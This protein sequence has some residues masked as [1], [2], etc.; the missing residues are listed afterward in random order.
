MEE[1]DVV[2]RNRVFNSSEKSQKHQHQGACSEEQGQ[3]A[4]KRTCK[5]KSA[6]FIAAKEG[7][8]ESNIRAAAMIGV[9][10]SDYPSNLPCRDEGASWGGW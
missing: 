3:E 4:E 8:E 2:Q 6:S 9:K 10:I 7:I 5:F 1:V